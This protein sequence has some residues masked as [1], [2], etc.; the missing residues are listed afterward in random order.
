[1]K[2]EHEK[3]GYISRCIARVNY[4]PDFVSTMKELSRSGKNLDGVI[5]DINNYTASNLGIRQSNY[6][7]LLDTI[8]GMNHPL[9][10]TLTSR[11]CRTTTQDEFTEMYNMLIK[12]LSKQVYL[13]AYKRYKKKVLNI[14]YIEGLDTNIHIHAVL[15]RPNH[16]D[17]GT[18]KRM[19]ANNWHCLAG[20]VH[21]KNLNKDHE[22]LSSYMTK[23]SSK[24]GFNTIQEALVIY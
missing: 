7:Y 10:V 1:M 16:V 17:K 3:R 19:I 2:S 21:I 11:F 4:P 15:D 20:T 18:F 14:G 8:K 5:N 6:E 9:F 13:R 12:K 24:Q 22:K 23:F